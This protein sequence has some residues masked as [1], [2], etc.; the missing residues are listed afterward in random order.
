[1][2]KNVLYDTRLQLNEPKLALDFL[3][4]N[5]G[6]VIQDDTDSPKVG[7]VKVY[8][9]TGSIYEVC[10][11]GSKIEN[12]TA[13]NKIVIHTSDCLQEYRQMALKGI[14]I[15]TKPYYAP[16]GLAFEI[17]DYWNNRYIMLEKRDYTDQ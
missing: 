8:D 17:S 13:N 12:N 9:R 3:I 5:L 4:R 14:L 7:T 15:I 2:N 1:M 16:E 10:F 6:F 11:H